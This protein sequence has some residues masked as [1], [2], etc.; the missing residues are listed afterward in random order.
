MEFDVSW[1]SAWESKRRAA[2]T[3]VGEKRRVGLESGMTRFSN[4]PENGGSYGE[5][6]A[7]CMYML[8]RFVGVWLKKISQRGAKG[9]GVV[10]RNMK[11]TF[12]GV[13]GFGL[14]REARRSSGSSSSSS[15]AAGGGE[16]VVVVV[17]V[18][19]IFSWVLIVVVNVGNGLTLVLLVVVVVV[20]GVGAAV[21]PPLVVAVVLVVEVADVVLVVE[22]AEVFEVVVGVGGVMMVKMIARGKQ[23]RRAQ[24]RENGVGDSMVFNFR[25]REKV[26]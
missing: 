15:A 19:L 8:Y 17:V 14:T 9:S 21:A 4:R 1:R 3:R 13:D 11:A 10:V 7:A 5:L 24:K 18:F 16:V 23:R 22:V 2:E 20:L 26:G 6:G 12:L 25:E